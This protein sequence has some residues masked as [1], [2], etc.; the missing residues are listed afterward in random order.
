MLPLFNTF[1]SSSHDY[2]AEDR[3]KGRI[4]GGILLAVGFG[5]AFYIYSV[6]TKNGTLDDRVVVL[7][8]IATLC[9]VAYLIEPRIFI[10]G[11]RN[12]TPQPILFK[13]L[14]YAVAILGFAIGMYVRYTFSKKFRDKI[15]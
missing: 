2:E 13:V 5:L 12:G 8:P 14:N 3:T 7:A 11:L 10:A 6:M 15:G 1:S 4:T 9:G